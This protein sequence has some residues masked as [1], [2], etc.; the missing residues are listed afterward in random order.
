[1]TVYRIKS[2]TRSWDG[3]TIGILILD[4]AYPCV[5]GNVG[6]ATTFPF[7]VRY[8]EVRGSS[9]ERLLNERDPELLKPFIDGARELEA[10]G[11]RAIT[12]ACGFMALFQKQVAE[13]VEIPVFLSSLLQVPFICRTLTSK[14][15]VGIITANAGV[16]TDE[17]FENVGITKE[18]PIVVY[19]ME[20]QEE[21]RTSILEEKGTLDSDLIEKEVVGVAQRMVQE[22]PEVAAILLECSDL[23]PYAAAV[24][25]ATGR[26]VFDFITMIKYVHSALVPTK[27]EG[28]M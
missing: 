15:K 26:P 13:A 18:M 19:G 11:V 5:P 3:E 9:I 22:H 20:D 25:A 24:H 23:P 1:M 12:G 16:L 21:F 28:Y 10:E 6:N 14:Q 17:H 27:Y 2:K 4:C 8:K 7:P